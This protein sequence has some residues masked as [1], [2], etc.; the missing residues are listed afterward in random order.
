MLLN[1]Y[2]WVKKKQSSFYFLRFISPL[3]P[4]SGHSC[5]FYGHSWYFISLVFITSFH[6]HPSSLKSQLKCCFLQKV[7]PD[8]LL[9]MDLSFFCV[10]IKFGM[11]MQCRIYFVLIYVIGGLV[12]FLSLLLLAHGRG[13]HICS[14]PYLVPNSPELLDCVLLHGWSWV[15]I[16]S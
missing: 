11:R 5:S 4:P 1:Y 8:F 12:T 10:L 15:D 2:L 14:S 16:R 7:F 6:F 3:P 13:N 9:K